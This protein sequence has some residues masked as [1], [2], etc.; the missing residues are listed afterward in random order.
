MAKDA[1]AGRYRS[2][3]DACTRRIW[4]AG[5]QGWVAAR[6]RP[7]QPEED[8]YPIEETYLRRLLDFGA[9]VK[10]PEDDN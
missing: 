5:K 3:Q 7:G 10:L 9:W 2:T 4:L 6:T 1:P 8:P